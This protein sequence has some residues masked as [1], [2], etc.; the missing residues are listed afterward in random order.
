MTEITPR[1]SVE[2]NNG[3]GS[4]LRRPYYDDLDAAR[5]AYSGAAHRYGGRR[6][7]LFQLTGHIEELVVDAPDR[8]DDAEGYSWDYGAGKHFTWAFSPTATTASSEGYLPISL[9][10]RGPSHPYGSRNGGSERGEL[11]IWPMRPARVVEW[12]IGATNRREKTSDD[13]VRSLQ[14]RAGRAGV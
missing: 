9:A 2:V 3:R 7:K 12:C 11:D 10:L 14:E 8:E 1:W 6:V 13:R 4:L 5:I